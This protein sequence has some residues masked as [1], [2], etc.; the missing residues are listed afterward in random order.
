VLAVLVLTVPVQLIASVMGFL[1]RDAVAA[2][3]MG[4]LAGTW[5]GICLT[6]LTS[7][8]GS[9]SS[10]LGVL[11]VA[12]GTAMLVPAVAA[13]AKPLA[14]LVMGVSAARF[15]VTGIAQ[16]RG[17]Q[18]WL[19]AAGWVG[20]ALALISLYAALAFELESLRQR[21]V[22]PTFRASSSRAALH[23]G[24]TDRPTDLAREP[25]VRP[26]L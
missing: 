21:G 2:T 5:A 7:P 24:L 18:D 14:A 1:A 23:D 22:L 9:S 19:T 10:G 17:S 15:L 11:L 25:G 4:I 8:P 16:L 12:A 26:Q 3:G 13:L 6:T 20:F